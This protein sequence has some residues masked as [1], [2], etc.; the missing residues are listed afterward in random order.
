[1]WSWSIPVNDDINYVPANVT[2]TPIADLDVIAA[3]WDNT[4]LT[5][6]FNRPVTSTN[7]VNYLPWSGTGDYNFHVAGSDGTTVESV[8]AVG[9]YS[10]TFTFK[11]GLLKA[12]D[13]MDLSGTIKDAGTGLAGNRLNSGITVVLT[14]TANG[15]VSIDGGTTNLPPHP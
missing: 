14:L 11:D 12:G 1:M 9:K 6:Y 13:Y 3:E 5:V 8:S 10:V 7:G 15:F 4:E 2:V